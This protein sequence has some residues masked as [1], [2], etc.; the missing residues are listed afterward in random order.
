MRRVK[1][2][3][4]FVNPLN[5][6]L[7]RTQLDSGLCF[8]LQPGVNECLAEVYKGNRAL[9]EN[10]GKSSL[11]LHQNVTSGRFFEMNE[12]GNLKLYPRTFILCHSKDPLVHL[13][14]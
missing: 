10:C 8:C 11:F 12:V 6:S 1:L 14:L 7:N 5:V 3:L 2:F 4:I 13:T 9:S